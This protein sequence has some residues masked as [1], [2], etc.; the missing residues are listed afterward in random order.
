[1]HVTIS[2]SRGPK[3]SDDHSIASGPA[4]NASDGVRAEAAVALRGVAAALAE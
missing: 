1:V 4:T 3:P 2:T